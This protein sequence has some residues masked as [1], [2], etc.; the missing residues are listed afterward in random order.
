[1]DGIDQRATQGGLLRLWESVGSE[2]RGHRL[3]IDVSGVLF[4]S[5]GV[6]ADLEEVVVRLGR[7]PEQPVTGETLAGL[8]VAPDLIR[9]LQALVRVAPLDEAT[10]VRTVP[11]VDFDR[12]ASECY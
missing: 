2:C 4:L 1:V 7:H 3:Q 8:G 11:L 12:A 10:L 5:G 9:P 6:F